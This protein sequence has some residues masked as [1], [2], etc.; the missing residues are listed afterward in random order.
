MSTTDIYREFDPNL[1]LPEDIK[2]TTVGTLSDVESDLPDN[3]DSD[4]NVQDETYDDDD[5]DINQ[6]EVGDLLDPPSS[7]T[8]ISQTVRTGN[9]GTQVVDVVIDV[10][11]IAEAIDYEYRITKA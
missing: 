2:N 10:E 11:D 3:G 7:F 9:D 5:S 4:I 1:D 6:D 8:V